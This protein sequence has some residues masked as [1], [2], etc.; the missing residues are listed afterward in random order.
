MGTVTWTDEK[1]DALDR[2]VNAGFVRVEKQLEVESARTDERFRRVD[3]R[4][5]EVDRRFDRIEEGTKE[6]FAE[7]KAEMSE[8]F[9]EVNG[10][11]G[12]MNERFGQIDVKFDA[13]QRTIIQVGGGLIGTV[14]VALI[15]VRAG[16]L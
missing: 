9:G 4:F 1:I 8:R 12:E 5:D 7:M 14:I 10:R 6:S 11:F 16:R 15:T 3:E 13:L 2:K